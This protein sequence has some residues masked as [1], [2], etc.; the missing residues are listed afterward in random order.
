MG[1]AAARRFAI[2]AY[3][4]A[5]PLGLAKRESTRKALVSA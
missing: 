2:L 5:C 3:A 4:L 1:L